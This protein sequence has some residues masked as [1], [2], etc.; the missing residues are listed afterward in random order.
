MQK[1]LEK[2]SNPMI[3][4][5]AAA[6]LRLLPH[7]PNF[8]PIGAMALFSGTYLDKKTAFAVPLLAMVASD[9]FIGF[10]SISSRLTVYGSFVLITL[11]GLWLKNRRT[12]SNIV[13]ATLSASVLFFI[14]TNF[15][16]WAFGTLYPRTIEG[17]VACY[18]AAIPFFRNTLASDLFYVGIFFG[19][20]ELVKNLAGQQKLALV[21]IGGSHDKK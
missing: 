18:A 9:F 15:G 12:A 8:A 4:V 6:F 13:L 3:F 21:K 10:D 5:V 14:V 16:V 11:L 1:Y 7:A 19:G 17:L 2:I 20:Y